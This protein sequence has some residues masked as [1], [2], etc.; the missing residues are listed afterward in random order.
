MAA[1]IETQGYRAL[2]LATIVMGVLIVA[3]TATL[4]FL[5]ARRLAGAE[6]SAPAGVVRLVEPAGSRIGGIAAE[7]GRLMVFVTGGGAPDRVRVLEVRAL[8]AGGVE[9]AAP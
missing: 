7:G 2:K 4:A 3:G 8:P 1:S 6:A 5:I 9:L